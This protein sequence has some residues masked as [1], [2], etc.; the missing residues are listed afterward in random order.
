M[1]IC[2]QIS[3][4]A[5]QERALVGNHGQEDPW[6]ETK[7]A[8]SLRLARIICMRFFFFER[9]TVMCKKLR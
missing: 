3:Y 2:Q 6:A 7:E 4:V 5:R 1:Y 8:R 9:E